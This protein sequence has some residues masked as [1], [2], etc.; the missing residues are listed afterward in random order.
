MVGNFQ[1]NAV[2][3]E[4]NLSRVQMM[5]ANLSKIRVMVDLALPSLDHAVLATRTYAHKQPR[6]RWIGGSETFV[7]QVI[8]APLGSSRSESTLVNRASTKLVFFMAE[9]CTSI[10]KSNTPKQHLFGT[11]LSGGNIGVK[12]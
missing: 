8:S 3:I 7:S 4:A 9:R 2:V 1:R 6:G 10:P 5:V 11:L 12:G